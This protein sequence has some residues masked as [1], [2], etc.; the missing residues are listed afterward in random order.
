[1]IISWSFCFSLMALCMANFFE[2]LLAEKNKWIDWKL[3][4]Y[5]IVTKHFWFVCLGE[6]HVAGGS[7]DFMVII[8]IHIWFR[9]FAPYWQQIPFTY[10]VYSHA[11]YNHNFIENWKIQR[12]KKLLA[13]FWMREQ[14]DA[15]LSKA[16]KFNEP[17]K[18]NVLH[19]WVCRIC[20]E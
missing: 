15:I 2:L 1:M 5:W 20:I 14:T 11:G 19:T 12:K 10:N 4:I 3:K 17:L 18:E 13:Q 16:E 9:W 8:N 7:I 6:W